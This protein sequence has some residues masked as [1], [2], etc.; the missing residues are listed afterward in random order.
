MQVMT[1]LGIQDYDL[2]HEL[3]E[4][5]AETANGIVGGPHE[6]LYRQ[7]YPEWGRLQAKQFL[8]SVERCVSQE[9]KQEK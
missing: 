6:P 8:G 7:L 5:E 9:K 2:I 1:K 4:G 3:E